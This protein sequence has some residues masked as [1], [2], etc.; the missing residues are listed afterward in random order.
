MKKY[1]VE[2]IGTFFL[3]F[4]VG[5]TVIPPGAEAKPHRHRVGAD[6]HDLC[7]RPH[8]W[9]ALQPGGHGSASGCGAAAR[10]RR[11]ALLARATGGRVR[12]R[13]ADAVL[14]GAGFRH[15]LP[16]EDQG[17]ALV[18]ELL[19]TALVWVVLNTATAKGTRTTYGLA[20]GTLVAAGALRRGHLG[21]GV[22]P[23]GRDRHPAWACPA[24]ATSG[25]S[26]WASSAARPRPPATLAWSTATTEPPYRRIR[27]AG[28]AGGLRGRLGQDLL[29]KEGR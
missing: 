25:S 26:S 17:H 27:D 28:G 23:G 20:I 19:F 9:W 5:C 22:Q 2:F 13:L 8:L 10:I 14:Q 3:V 6:G 16:I 12:R 1:I 29:V 7:R 4:T 21:Q 18:A 15:L 11:P 24:G